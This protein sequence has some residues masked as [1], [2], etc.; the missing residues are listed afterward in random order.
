ML[1]LITVLLVSGCASFKDSAVDRFYQNLTAKYNIYF[2][3]EQAYLKVVQ[4]TEAN[5]KDEYQ[6]ILEIYRF[7]DES[8]GK[9]NSGQVDIVLTKCSKVIEKRKNSKWIDDSYLLIGKAYFYKHEP[10]L[11]LETF[12]FIEGEYSDADIVKEALIFHAKCLYMEEKYEEAKAFASLIKSK[13]DLPEKLNKDLLLTEAM[14][15]IKNENFGSAIN[16]LKEAIE[17]ENNKYNKSRYMFI[18]GQIYQKIGNSEESVKYYKKVIKRNPPYDMAFNA[19]IEISRCNIVTDERT[20]KPIRKMLENMLLDD[21]NIQY[22]DQIY[23]EMALLEMKLGNMKKAEEFL[24]LSIKNNSSNENLKAIAYMN[25]AEYYFG[26]KEYKKSKDYYDSTSQYLKE[27]YPDYKKVIAKNKSLGELVKYLVIAETEDSLQYLANL[28]V[29]SRDSIIN[30][31]YEYELKQKAEAEKIEQEK[32]QAEEQ[33]MRMNRQL[34]QNRQQG[35]MQPP[36]MP[37][38]LSGSSKWYFYNQSAINLGKSEFMVKWGKRSLEDNW[39]ISQKNTSSEEGFTEEEQQTENIEDIKAILSEEDKKQIEQ[40]LTDIPKDK[41]K[42]YLDIPFAVAQMDA[43]KRREIEALKKSGDMFLEN[44]Q[45]TANAIKSYEK[46]LLKYPDN[47]YAAQVYY[48]LYKLY[49]KPEQK[50]KRQK[51]KDSLLVKFPGSDYVILLDNPDFI[52]EKLLTRNAEINELYSQAYFYYS[53]GNCEKLNEIVDLSKSKYPG[54]NKRAYFDYLKILCAAKTMKKE[55]LIKTLNDFQ[56]KYKEKELND[57]VNILLAYLNDELNASVSSTNNN[58]PDDKKKENSE[59]I[60]VYRYNTDAAHFFVYAFESRKFNL[61]D[62]KTNF[63]DFN[64]KFYSLANLEINSLM[65]NNDFQLIIVK[66]FEDKEAAFDYIK[67]IK[68]DESFL[69]KIKNRNPQVFIITAENLQ[70][71]I[72]QKELNSYLDFYKRIYFPK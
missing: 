6:G 46:L 47:R 40:Y 44:L 57:E 69:T 65:L 11:A 20:A 31:A 58:S 21:K 41:Q 1:L 23:L 72:V 15:D 35:F 17:K 36:G 29:R 45:D 25:L 60:N 52:K 5:F 30:K 64:A 42:Y 68:S 55:E 53:K 71:M 27:S 33:E 49:I 3:G 32:K 28:P 10:K 43:S 2:N 14:I 63:S 16:N 48:T 18:L 37:D 39:R 12:Q 54:N 66:E 26:I 7:P 22:Y 56:L 13:G 67:T 24:K 38:D 34:M 19:K 62:V 8:A 61:T 51:Q 70:L 9:S 50:D 59:K 4:Q